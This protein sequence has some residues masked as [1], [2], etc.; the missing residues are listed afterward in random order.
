MIKEFSKTANSTVIKNSCKWLT[1]YRLDFWPILKMKSISLKKL[2]VVSVNIP[3]LYHAWWRIETSRIIRRI[4]IHSQSIVTNDWRQLEHV[5]K[6]KNVS[7]GLEIQDKQAITHAI[8]KSSVEVLRVL[9]DA[10]MPID[11]L[12]C[13]RSLGRTEYPI[14]TAIR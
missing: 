11:L 12:C 5:L 6:D 1:I 8:E 4:I 13:D 10:L 2:Y 7:S 9:L 3:C 14:M